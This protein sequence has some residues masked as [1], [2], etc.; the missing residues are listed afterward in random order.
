MTKLPA[1]LRDPERDADEL[2]S[3]TLLRAGWMRAT[4]LPRWVAVWCSETSAMVQALKEQVEIERAAQRRYLL[5]G[6]LNGWITAA[7]ILELWWVCAVLVAASSL[8]YWWPNVKAW[9]QRRRE[10]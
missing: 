4:W 6:N 8:V 10:R 3:V 9:W 2:V 5:A 1:E 7:A